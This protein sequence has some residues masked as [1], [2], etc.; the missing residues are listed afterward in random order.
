MGGPRSGTTALYE[1]LSDHPQVVASKQKE[2]H[3]FSTDF[4][5]FSW[6]SNEKEYLNL[7]PV[8]PEGS[9]VVLE[10]SPLY[11]Y[12]DVAI[13]NIFD[14][15]PSSKL[16]ILARKP[17]EMIPSWHAQVLYATDENI[18]RFEEA[19]RATAK[20]K[21]GEQIP[22]TCRNSEFL[23]YDEIGAVGS[24]TERALSI[25]PSEQVKVIIFDE[26]RR[27]TA[28][29]YRST[30][31]F[32]GL[33][34]DGRTSFERTNENRI[35]RNRLLRVLIQRPP[36]WT[37]TMARYL[38]TL[39]GVKR[40]K[41]SKILRGVNTVTASRPPLGGELREEINQVYK[42]D[43]RLLEEITSADLSGWSE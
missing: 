6:A 1:Y 42:G 29:V 31:D 17:A 27:D 28:G 25:F 12:S 36:N 32:L 21:N 35:Y 41:V 24:Q 7:F 19:W 2:P 13:K 9:K 43:R 3:Y 30:L 18:G 37:L 33:D 22:R 26:F 16:I 40:L 38:R 20:R 5:D 14:F 15:N 10:A 23:F 4:R 8:P 11:L 34:N 39:L